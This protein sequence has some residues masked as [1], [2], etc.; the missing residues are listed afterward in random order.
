IQTLG[1]SLA[2]GGTTRILAATS[3]Q[4]PQTGQV[5]ISTPVFA[6]SILSLNSNGVMV[7]QAGIPSIPA[8]RAFRT[9]VEKGPSVRSGIAVANPSAEAVNVGLETAGLTSPLSMPANGQT[10][11]FLDEIPGFSGLPDSFEG[12]LEVKSDAPVAVTGLR[13]HTNERGEF[14]ITA[15]PPVDESKP[16]QSTELFFP[17]F[18]DGAGY[19]MQFIVFGDTAS[20]T[21]SFF[22]QSGNLVSLEF[23]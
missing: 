16:R 23:R 15:T 1:Y 6:F 19:S 11:M 10:A 9:Y 21:I 7:T 14:L 3:S 22:N 17:H 4:R 5:R 12:V 8:G 20:G 13:S 2:P 18:A